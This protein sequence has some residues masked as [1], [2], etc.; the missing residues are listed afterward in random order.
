MTSS[1]SEIRAQPSA[2]L[3]TLSGTLLPFLLLALSLLVSPRFLEHYISLEWRLGN[4]RGPGYVLQALLVGAAAVSMLLRRRISARLAT[5][6]P[7]RRQLVLALVA[8]TMSVMLTL[9]VAE[10][11]CRLLDLPVRY[12]VPRAEDV[13]ATFDS[14]LG[15]AYISN[16]SVIS[17]F[18]VPPRRIPS[19]FDDI[20]RS[21]WSAIPSRWGM[22]WFSTRPLPDVS[23]PWL[24]SPTRW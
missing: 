22:V 20:A 24:T 5:V 7:S 8:G 17:S 10:T 9:G 21:C 16:R 6:F 13:T 11:A 14:E 2:P 3:F 4:I 12:R 23:K 1:T 18:G 15:W 19:H